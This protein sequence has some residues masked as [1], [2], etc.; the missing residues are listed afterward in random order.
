LT[1][2]LLSVLIPHAKPVDTP[3][4]QRIKHLHAIKRMSVAR[5]ALCTK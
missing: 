5:T 2:A 4:R 3:Y 1:I